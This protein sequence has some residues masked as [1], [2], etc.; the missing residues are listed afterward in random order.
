V[1]RIYSLFFVKTKNQKDLLLSFEEDIKHGRLEKVI[2]RARN[3]SEQESI[4]AV[5][6]AGA[7]AASSFGGKDEIQSKM[8]EVLSVENVKLE[9]RTGFLSMFANVSTL[10]GLLGTIIGLIQ[11][12]AS[13]ANMN[14][15]EKSLLLT[16]GVALAMN[17]TAYGL[18]V[19]IPTLI[20]Y[21]ILVNRTNQLQ[22]ELNQSAFKAFNWL[23]FNYE[24]TARKINSSKSV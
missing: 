4:A 15:A 5:I 13:I 2:S 23:S 7:Q 18:I 1:E 9:R 14:G 6:Q 8:D 24:S 10:L 17:T 22:E 21:A 19:A 11:A 3:L 16:Q 20:I 12:F